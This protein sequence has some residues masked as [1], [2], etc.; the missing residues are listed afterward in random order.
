MIDLQMGLIVAAIAL[1]GGYMDATLGMGYGTALTPILL[2]MGLPVENVV[3]AVLISQFAIGIFAGIAH[4]KVGNANLAPKTLNVR[5]IVRAIQ[6]YG[7]AESA[8]RGLP[9]PLQVTL[10]LAASGVA[11]SAVAAAVAISLPTVVVKIY[12]AVLI[13]AVGIVVLVVRNR[14]TSFSWKRVV[15]LGLIASFNKGISGG[16]YGPVVTAGQIT[17]GVDG[18]SAVAVTSVAE[19][20]SCLAAV[21][22]YLIAGAY[23]ALPLAGYLVVGGVVSVPFSA[24]T[25]KAINVQR[26]TL[27]IGGSTLVMGFLSLGKVLLGA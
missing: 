3:P 24:L 8:R 14:Q 12:I 17:A 7:V 22:V 15:G 18:K 23:G 2:L 19:A 4:H 11:G 1:V 9:K 26:F 10:V 27:L 13:I 5:K 6:S 21:V 25:V 20:V 16:G